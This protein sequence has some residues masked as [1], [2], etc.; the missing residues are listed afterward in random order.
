MPGVINIG[1]HF[2]FIQLRQQFASWRN[3]GD[4]QAAKAELERAP[5]WWAAARQTKTHTNGHS[6]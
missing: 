1:R 3:A 2:W 5:G 4:C 6:L